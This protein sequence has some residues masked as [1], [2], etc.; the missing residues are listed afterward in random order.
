[1]SHIFDVLLI[2]FS[3]IGNDDLADSAFRAKIHYFL[4]PNQRIDGLAE[5]RLKRFNV[6]T[7]YKQQPS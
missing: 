3:P 7:L 6:I 5:G 1:M 2:V 4:K